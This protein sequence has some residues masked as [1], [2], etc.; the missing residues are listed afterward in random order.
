[1]Q[2]LD[3]SPSDFT[4]LVLFKRINFHSFLIEKCCFFNTFNIFQDCG[5]KLIVNFSLFDGNL[6]VN[7]P[8][9]VY[10]RFFSKILLMMMSNNFCNTMARPIAAPHK[11]FNNY[12]QFS[13]EVF[14]SWN[15]IT[16]FMVNMGDYRF[17]MKS[18]DSQ[19]P[20]MRF[21]WHF[22]ICLFPLTT[23]SIGVTIFPLIVGLPRQW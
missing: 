6:T 8:E 11:L 14:F 19:T 20:D 23:L 22:W 9:I 4:D 10:F 3:M 18:N 5:C 12:H 16:F 7:H 2:S 1:M 17:S 15:S 13:N 21:Y